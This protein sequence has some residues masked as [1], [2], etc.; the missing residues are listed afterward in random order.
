MAQGAYFTIER[1]KGKQV[2]VDAGKCERILTNK[3]VRGS[4]NTHSIK[5]TPKN[6]VQVSYL[7]IS[8]K[9]TKRVFMNS[10]RNLVSET[11][12]VAYTVPYTR[13]HI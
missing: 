11:L 2:G 13:R 7:T 10:F 4:G 6:K 9:N 12:L 3:D 5:V 1:K 8:S